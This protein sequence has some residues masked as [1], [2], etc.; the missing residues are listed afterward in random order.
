V[1]PGLRVQGKRKLCGRR[2]F[3]TYVCT[4]LGVED[5]T[6]V[7]VGNGVVVK[8]HIQV[9]ARCTEMFFYYTTLVR[10][11]QYLVSVSF[12]IS[13]RMLI[14]RTSTYAHRRMQTHAGAS[15]RTSI[16]T[17]ARTAFSPLP[18]IG[19]AASVFIFSCSFDMRFSSF[20]MAFP[21]PT[22]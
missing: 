20:S 4:D 5:R 16:Q 3:K 6:K 13:F 22:R 8:Q 9:Q 14:N 11:I 19:L 1:A 18:F 17:D 21:L 15:R 7:G 10:F 2:V 12:N